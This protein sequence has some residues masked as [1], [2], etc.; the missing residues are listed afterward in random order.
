M[1]C[2]LLASGSKGNSIYIGNDT[3]AIVVDAGVGYLKRTL[4]DLRLDTTRVRALCLTHEHSDHVR[5]AKAFVKAMHIP[6]YATGGTLDASVRGGFVPQSAELVQ[7]R[8][9]IASTLGSLSI[10]AFRTYHDAAEPSGFVVDDGESR[11]GVCL[12]TH[13]VTPAMLDILRECDAVVLESN[14]CSPA[15]Q[16]DRFPECG[17][18]RRCGANCCGNRQVLRLYPRYLKDRI[19]D[20]GHLSNEDSSAVVADLANEVGV[21][22]LAHLSENYNRPNLARESAEDAAGESGAQIFVSDQL[23]G[24]REQRLVRFRI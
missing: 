3:D 18:C 19:R 5:S 11:I 14:Y 17:E 23:T 15:M 22:A 12:D 9:K 2:V 16:T 24:Y 8:D 4:E 7:C 10:T 13:E 1:E 20:D 21:I 6:I